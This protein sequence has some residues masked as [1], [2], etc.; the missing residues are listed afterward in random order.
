MLAL[1]KG[2][3]AAEQEAA[4]QVEALSALGSEE[5]RHAIVRDVRR[6]QS[7]PVLEEIAEALASMKD[8]VLPK[9]PIGKAVGYAENHW[10]ALVRF[11]E[12]G[13]IPID[14]NAIEREMRV[15]AVGRRNWTFCGSESGGEWAA[16]LYGLLG[17]CRLQGVNPFIWLQ[18]VLD[19][20]RDHPA[21][22]MAELTPRRWGIA[23]R[24]EVSRNSD[25]DDT[26]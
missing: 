11:S 25:P 23:R 15:V 21:E 3:Y 16:R 13:A 24:E 5:E 22:R 1:I 2:L 18:D 26:S 12:N 17:T 20:V 4:K 6:E 14:T 10:D 8:E 9:S 7:I 19:R